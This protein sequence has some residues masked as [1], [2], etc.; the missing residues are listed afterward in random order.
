MCVNIENCKS[1]T[2]YYNYTF[3]KTP[4]GTLTR[5]LCLRFHFPIK[6]TNPHFLRNIE[7][8]MK[9]GRSINQSI[10]T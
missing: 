3:L 10:H 5:K 6:E 9:I 2:F 8:W 7:E 4:G 1:H